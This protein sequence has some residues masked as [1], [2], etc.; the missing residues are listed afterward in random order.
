MSAAKTELL[1]RAE[2]ELTRTSERLE[3]LERRSSALSRKEAEI[4]HREARLEERQRENL[5]LRSSLQGMSSYSAP[6]LF[7]ID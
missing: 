3:E 1:R 2:A 4:L 5:T 7:I 6:A